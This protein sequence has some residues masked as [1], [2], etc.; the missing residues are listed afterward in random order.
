MR[1]LNL[2]LRHCYY[3]DTPIFV[4]YRMPR[5]AVWSEVIFCTPCF[6]DSNK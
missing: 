3:C 6:K 4:F 1:I 5:G 2:I